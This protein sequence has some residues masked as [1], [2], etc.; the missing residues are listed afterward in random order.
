MLGLR[1]EAEE[2]EETPLI[3][4]GSGES[5]I[6]H[7]SQQSIYLSITEEEGEN[8]FN[9]SLFTAIAS[10]TLFLPYFNN[11]ELTH[12]KYSDFLYFIYL[13]LF[14]LAFLG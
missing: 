4:E 11:A 9:P 5:I 10:R 13:P 1:V 7:K 6:T 2:E 8:S 12:Q 14:F 3:L